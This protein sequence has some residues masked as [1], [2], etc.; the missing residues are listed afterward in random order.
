MTMT[1]DMCDQTYD[2]CDCHTWCH[3][4]PYLLNQKEEKKRRKIKELE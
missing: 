4:I 1:C 2:S 3:M